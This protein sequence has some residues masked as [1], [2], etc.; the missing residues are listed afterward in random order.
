[1]GDPEAARVRRANPGDEAQMWEISRSIWSGHDYVPAAWR[2][3]LEDPAGVIQ[4]VEIQGRMVGFQH[5]VQLPGEITWLEGIRVAQE[6]RR[7]G[8][9]QL[10]LQAGLQWAREGNS[11]GVYVAVDADNVASHELCDRNGLRVIETFSSVAAAPDANAGGEAR[12]AQAFEL[13]AVARFLRLNAGHR[14]FY[15][16]GWTAYPLT[17]DR[18]RVLLA[19]HSVLV[20]RAGAI[21]AVAIATERPG[22]SVIRLGLL[23]GDRRDMEDISRWL[24][25]AAG[26]ARQ[27]IGGMVGMNDDSRAALR[28]AEYTIGQHEMVLRGFE[29]RP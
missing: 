3:W 24:R 10:L 8:I 5:A 20:N 6:S 14:Q 26:A 22:R 17:R 7:Q 29:L 1:M 15:T 9:G 27:D 13:D 25:S 11:R 18:L 21:R 16:E 23:R 4:V 19:M 2:R 28:A 12:P